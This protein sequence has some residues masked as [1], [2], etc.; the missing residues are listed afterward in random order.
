V[1]NNRLSRL[2]DTRT[3]SYPED[4][5]TS[6]RYSDVT[7]DLPATGLFLGGG[8]TSSKHPLTGHRSKKLQM[9]GPP[10]KSGDCHHWE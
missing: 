6:G 2:T 9:A 10:H 3:V 5:E 7:T 4:Q 8:E 1:M